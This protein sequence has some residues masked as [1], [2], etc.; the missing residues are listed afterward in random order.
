MFELIVNVR[1]GK[2]MHGKTYTQVLWCVAVG[3]ILVATLFWALSQT[4]GPLCNANGPQP[5]GLIWHPL[6]GVMAVLLYF[7]WRDENAT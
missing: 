1:D 2:F 3:C 7:F 4:G 6:A 5:H